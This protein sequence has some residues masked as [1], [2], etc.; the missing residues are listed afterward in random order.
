MT[1]GPV[2]LT[3][4]R[5]IGKFD[6]PVTPKDAMLIVVEQGA[7]TAAYDG[8]V[9]VGVVVFVQSFVQQ[10]PHVG[11]SHA[12]F[13]SIIP[14]P[15]IDGHV[16]VRFDVYGDEHLCVFPQESTSAEVIVALTGFG[17]R[18]SAHTYVQFG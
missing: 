18:T 15:H 14:S 12:S 10:D 17:E 11:G 4:V 7:V 1:L 2:L 5:H 9:V 8:I 13:L 3:N 6:V 16:H